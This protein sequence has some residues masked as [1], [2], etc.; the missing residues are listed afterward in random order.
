MI[1]SLCIF[2]DLYV[3]GFLAVTFLNLGRS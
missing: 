1:I 2:L 3:L